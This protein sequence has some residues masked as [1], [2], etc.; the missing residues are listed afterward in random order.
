MTYEHYKHAT[1]VNGTSLLDAFT[2][3]TK[4]DVAIG[5]HMPIVL[6]HVLVFRIDT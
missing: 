5:L 4:V 1:L 6:R 3:F 2:H